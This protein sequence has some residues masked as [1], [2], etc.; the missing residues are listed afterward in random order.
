MQFTK[1]HII[2]VAVITTAAV[3]LTTVSASAADQ[4]EPTAGAVPPNSVGS[5]Q[6]I[7][8]S[9]W[10]QDLAPAVV[11]VLRTPKEG[12]VWQKTLNANIVT[13]DKLSPAV[14]N[15]LNSSGGKVS[16]VESDG[17]YP[18][19]TDEANNL[20]NIDIGSQGAQS[21]HLWAAGAA[22]QASWVM[23][24]PGKIAV[25]G[26][27]GD[28]DGDDSKIRVVTSAPVQIAKDG[29]E[30]KIVYNPIKDDPAGSFL[31]NGWLVEGFNEGT[32]ATMVRPWETCLKL[33]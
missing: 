32:E 19:R 22:R 15:K 4:T 5:S 17:P 25:G 9:L 30:Y 16:K 26:G 21:T 7:N 8:E 31:A 23:C 20:Q 33:G 6:V 13:E 24:A 29:G 18:G 14:R 2:A 3:G 27:F 11:S 12:S 10:Q 28:N 1:R